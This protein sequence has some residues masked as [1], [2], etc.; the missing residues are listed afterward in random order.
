LIWPPKLTLGISQPTPKPCLSP[1]MQA[2][3]LSELITNQENGVPPTVQ[4]SN[5]TLE[6]PSPQTPPFLATLSTFP[7]ISRGHVVG[8]YLD[9]VS[10]MPQGLIIALLDQSGSGGRDL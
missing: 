1:T 3:K 4:N 9:S 8:N 6:R 5:Q 10:Q 2:N 7:Q